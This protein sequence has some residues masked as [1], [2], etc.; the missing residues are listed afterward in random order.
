MW[1]GTKFGGCF[2]GS[3]ML[4]WL[5]LGTKALVKELKYMQ[6][7]KVIKKLKGLASANAK[8]P[9]RTVVSGLAHFLPKCN[10]T[11]KEVSLYMYL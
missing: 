2:H 11:N 3:Q 5:G 4:V 6:H 10:T 1:Y 8:T 7:I 9:S